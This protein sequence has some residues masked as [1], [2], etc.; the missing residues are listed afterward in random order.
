MKLLTVQPA[1]VPWPIVEPLSCICGPFRMFVGHVV[2]LDVC[3]RWQEL[4]T[5]T[6]IRAPA[7][8]VAGRLHRRSQMPAC[9]SHKGQPNDI[10]WRRLPL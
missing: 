3:C 7:L 4:C 1:I 8:G 2:G 10:S 6:M 9:H 5:I